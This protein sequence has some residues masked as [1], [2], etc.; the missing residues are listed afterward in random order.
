MHPDAA[1]IMFDA[2]NPY[3]GVSAGFLFW[4][5]FIAGSVVAPIVIVRLMFALI[6]PSDPFPLN[7]I[8]PLGFGVA[9][10]RL[11]RP[12]VPWIG[13]VGYV[14]AMLVVLVYTTL[15]I[16]CASYGSCL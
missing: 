11:L 4:I 16:A 6:M 7:F 1:L 2:M 3:W 15:I 10:L 13:V 8:V 14:I 5:Q 12:P 9:N